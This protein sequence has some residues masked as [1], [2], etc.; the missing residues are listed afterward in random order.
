VELLEAR[1]RAQAGERLV[2]AEPW[3]AH[4]YN[5]R[6]VS[7]VLTTTNGALVNRQAVV[8]A[9][10]RVAERASLDPAGLSTPTG[11]RTAVTVLYAEAG[12]DL[13]DIARNVGLA[14]EA[15]TVGHVRA[16]GER[17]KA[18]AA[19]VAPMLDPRSGRVSGA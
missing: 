19:M 9:I 14:S 12:L 16:L 13:S 5:G 8:K 6:A 4:S 15:T 2:S 7:P 1:W 3:A 18:R 10:T 17:P 11:R